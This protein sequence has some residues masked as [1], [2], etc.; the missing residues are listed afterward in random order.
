[1][2][3]AEIV[4]SVRPTTGFGSGVHR[5]L[6]VLVAILSAAVLVVTAGSQIYDSNLFSMS[7]ATSILAGDRPYR[8]FFESGVPLAAY[9][10]AG[11][12]RL[13]G[14]RLISEFALQ[15]LFI[16]A[17]VVIAF[18]LGIQLSRSI[19]A[20]LVMT[21]IALV[22]LAVTPTYHHSKLFFFPL[23]IWAAWAYMDHPGVRRSAI[24][25]VVT[26]VA[27]LSR[28]DYGIYIGFAAV[29][30]LAL[31][32]VVHSASRSVASIVVD[33]AAYGAA[34]AVVVAP[35]AI[36]VQMNEGLI[37]YTRARAGL[38]Q[39][40]EGFPYASLLK[41]N[42]I[43]A[44]SREPLPAPT[45]GVVSFLWN[46]NVN[47]A[48]R[49]QLEHQ[50]GLRFL[51]ERDAL[52]R[53]KYE[54]SNVYSLD[55]LKLDPYINDGAGFQWKLLNDFRTY[56]PG[57]DNALLWLQQM[58]LLTPLL[59]FASGAWEIWRRRHQSDL[60]TADGVRMVFAGVFL[61]V[62]DTALFRQPPYVVVVAPVT[63]ALGARFLVA[64][65]AFRR[66]IAIGAV[67][68]TS[69][70]AWVFA[71]AKDT[72]LLRPSRYADSVSGAFALLLTSPPDEGHLL[73]RYLRECTAPGDRLLVTGSTPFNV[74]YYVQRPIAGGHL[75]WKHGWR[76]DPQREQES[77]AL[78]RTQSVPFAV[79]TND[80][81]LIDFRRYP[82]IREYLLKNYAEVEGSNG[83]ILVDTRRRPSGRYGPNGFPCFR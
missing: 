59:L 8:D 22:I 7:E 2:S 65:S 6:L 14:Y 58:A 26:A 45:P 9:M 51:D 30:A 3:G 12:Q 31:A 40:P 55:L 56:V 67:V 46:E 69:V 68:I 79:S 75:A 11:A 41:L 42:P 32:R 60:A 25:G 39:E 72:P 33:G 63:A 44:L 52:G 36:V 81:V 5:G 73:T 19:A 18:H 34:V 66:G 47:E 23:T 4:E 20:T 21:A 70:S 35:W 24:L 83:N 82:R 13:F 27:F 71:Y 28:H 80:P 16:V 74:S 49:H 54:A 38:Y 61:A 17:G 53:L 10:S 43:R 15:W 77:L 1:V 62:V 48:A 78:L 29:V 76:S 57:L 37:E 50:H 64:P